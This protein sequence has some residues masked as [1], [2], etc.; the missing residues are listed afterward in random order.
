MKRLSTLTVIPPAALMAF[1]G[2][3]VSARQT[4]QKGSIGIKCD[5][6]GFAEMA[7]ISIDS[8]V[9]AAL[10]QVPG[11]VLRAELE[12]EDGYLVYGVE[13]VKTDHQIV[14]VKVD[15]GNGTILKTDYDHEDKE[16]NG[17]GDSNRGREN[18]KRNRNQG[19][20]TFRS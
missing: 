20:K 3:N 15:A 14:D 8:A 17:R 9:N 5:E 11:K 19:R 2:I 1:G 16:H 6:A 4:N 12:N 13:I 18:E 10:K 7:K